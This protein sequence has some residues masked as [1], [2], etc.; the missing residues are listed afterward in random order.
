MTRRH[1]FL[2]SKC[3]EAHL[4]ISANSAPKLALP[5]MLVGGTDKALTISTFTATFQAKLLNKNQTLRR[6]PKATTF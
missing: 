2:P 3:N 6:N 4:I 1:R 5:E